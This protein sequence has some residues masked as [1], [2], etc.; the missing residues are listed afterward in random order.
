MAPSQCLRSISYQQH[1]C[2]SCFRT[3]MR[4]RP[5]VELI[6][7]REVPSDGAS[8][9]GKEIPA[10]TV[11]CINAWVLHRD[12][13]VFPESDAFV[14]ERWLQSSPEELKEMEQKLLRLWGW[15]ADLYRKEHFAHGD[16]ECC[17]TT[18]ARI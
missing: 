6:L 15:I 12:P 11:V 17:P 3:D 16:A 10:G 13:Q 1:S 14:P 9:C 2:S 18:A 8:I 4:L 7:E 5:S